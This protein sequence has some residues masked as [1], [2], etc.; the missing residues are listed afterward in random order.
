MSRMRLANWLLALL[1]PVSAAMAQTPGAAAGIAP[2][3][4]PTGLIRQVDGSLLAPEIDVIKRRG[5]LIVAILGVDQPPYF[6]EKNGTLAGLDV[7]LARELAAGLGVRLEVDRSARTFDQVLDVLAEGKADLAISKLSRTLRRA[8]FVV[9][10]QPYLSLNQALLVDRVAFAK[11]TQR[12]SVGEAVRGYKGKIGVWEQSSYANYVAKQFPH[13]EVR[14]YASWDAVIDALEAGE[15]EAAYRDEYEIK[16]ILAA[17]PAKALRLR[18]IT[19]DD[20]FDRFSVA[21]NLNAPAL[22]N[23]VNLYLEMRGEPLDINDVIQASR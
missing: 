21:I 2:G 13:A 23:Y 18:M 1:M 19:L 8:G 6:F 10:S 5:A 3:R 14:R 4:S 15:I 12:Q 17:E 9:F 16:K 11:R 7:G 20:V 22:L